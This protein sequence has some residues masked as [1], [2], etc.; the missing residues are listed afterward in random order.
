MEPPSSDEEGADEEE[1]EE[2]ENVDENESI[3]DDQC[4]SEAETEIGEDSTSETSTDEENDN[5]DDDDNVPE[6]QPF[7]K[8]LPKKRKSNEK[9]NNV[10]SKKVKKNPYDMPLLDG[11]ERQDQVETADINVSKWKASHSPREAFFL[12]PDHYIYNNVSTMKKFVDVLK[13]KEIDESTITTPIPPMTKIVSTNPRM[14]LGVTG[15]RYIQQ[16][17]GGYRM[18]PVYYIAKEY[19]S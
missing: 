3:E 2:E 16:N 8:E 5:D 15:S 14:T 18:S 12:G 13:K 10:K 4:E 11:W 9:S 19:V 7:F 6:S 1:E 17:G